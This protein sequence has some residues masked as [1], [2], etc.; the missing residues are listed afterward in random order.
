ML[1]SV[2]PF[3]VAFVSLMVVVGRNAMTNVLCEVYKEVNERK[4]CKQFGR[5]TVFCFHPTIG[6]NSVR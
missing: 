5:L 4:L 2:G 6:S 1:T 3:L